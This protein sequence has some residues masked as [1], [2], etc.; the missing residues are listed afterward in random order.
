M[1]RGERIKL[2][3]H[4]KYNRS[5]GAD[6][7]ITDKD[8][9]EIIKALEQEPCEDCISRE[10]LDKALYERFHEE[11]SP[12]NITDV[13]L[14]AVRN[15]VREF[16]P[17]NPQEPK[18]GHWIEHKN[19]GMSYI[20]CSECSCWFLRMYLTRNSYCPNCGTKMIE[21]QESEEKE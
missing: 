8:A 2:I 17:A 13:R 15:F 9:D 21:P 10:K 12:N 16:P 4:L 11:D 20:E 5:I 19:N 7:M 18:T 6:Y 1:T 14:G 3:R